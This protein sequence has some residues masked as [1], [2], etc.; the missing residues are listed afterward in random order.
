VRCDKSKRGT[1]LGESNNND[2]DNNNNNSH[3]NNNYDDNRVASCLR[4]GVD[5]LNDA[6]RGA[7]EQKTSGSMWHYAAFTCGF[8][9]DASVPFVTEPSRALLVFTPPS[10]TW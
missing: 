1:R 5:K 4:V 7:H 9:W 8:V 2:D 10:L 3:S 6:Q